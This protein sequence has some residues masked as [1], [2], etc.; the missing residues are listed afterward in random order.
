MIFQRSK[1]NSVDSTDGALYAWSIM[2]ALRTSYYLMFYHLMFFAFLCKGEDGIDGKDGEDGEQGE[3]VTLISIFSSRKSEYR[4]GKSYSEAALILLRFWD[5]N[6]HV[7]LCF[8]LSVP[9]M[10]L[11]ENR[12]KQK[13]VCVLSTPSES[14]VKM[15][16]TPSIH[17]SHLAD[18]F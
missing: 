16:P 14:R 5:K 12:P 15:V 7:D 9:K 1:L 6:G 4:F 11:N 8:W 18:A 13:R 2:G 17:K 10:E 3:E